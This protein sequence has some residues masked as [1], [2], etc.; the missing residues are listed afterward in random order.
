MSEQSVEEANEMLRK[1][2]KR[3]KKEWMTEECLKPMK[4]GKLQRPKIK[5]HIKNCAKRSKLNAPKQRELVRSAVLIDKTAKQRKQVKR[6]TQRSEESY[7]I[8]HKQS[9]RK[10]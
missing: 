6:L 7:W 9:K 2:G 8:M 4:I 5:Y 10:Y 3:K 1:V